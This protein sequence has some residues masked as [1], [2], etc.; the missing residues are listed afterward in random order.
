[1]ILLVLAC[2]LFKVRNRKMYWLGT[3]KHSRAAKMTPISHVRQ[4]NT[5]LGANDR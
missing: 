2:V 5:I 3:A 4:N 1:M